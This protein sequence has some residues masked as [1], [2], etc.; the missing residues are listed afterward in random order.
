MVR[1]HREWVREIVFFLTE[2][3]FKL[4]I[5]PQERQENIFTCLSFVLRGLKTNMFLSA[6]HQHYSG[7]LGLCAVFQLAELGEE[8]TAL[9]CCIGGTRAAG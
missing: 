7:G 5:P 2:V 9:L 6:R 8:K 3:N 4:S 1:S